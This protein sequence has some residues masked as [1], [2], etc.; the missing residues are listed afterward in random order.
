MGL[1]DLFRTAL[2]LT[3]RHLPTTIVLVL[4]TVQMVA[5][6]VQLWWPVLFAPVLTVL[7]VSLFLERIFAKYLSEEDRA[8]LEDRPPEDPKE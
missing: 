2:V 8:I 3:L 5:I 4:L 6:G 7:L 1:K